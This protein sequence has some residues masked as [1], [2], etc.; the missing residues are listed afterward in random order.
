MKVISL[1]FL[2]LFYFSPIFAQH[3]IR[4]VVFPELITTDF[5][6]F[7]TL[8]DL[9]G[10]PRIFC[11]EINA[12]DKFVKMAGRV[13]WK[14]GGS[15]DFIEIAWFITR[16]FVARTLCNDDIGKVDVRVYDHRFNT[17]LIQENL[18]YGKPTGEYRL[19]VQLYDST[20]QILLA[21]DSRNLLFLNPAQTITIV[22]PRTNQSYDAGNLLVEWTPIPGVSEYYIKANERSDQNQ[23]LEDALQS[24]TPLVNKSVGGSNSINLRDVLDRELRPGSEIVVQVSANIPGPMGETK[25]FSEIVNFFILNPETQYY[26]QLLI[27]FYNALNR[28]GDNEILQLLREGQIDPAKL[29]IRNEDGS[30]M[31]FEELVNFLEMN[32]NNILRITKE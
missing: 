28:L 31:T 22:N 6:A 1:L 2:T 11:A 32:T 30:I 3:T 8:N 7:L 19:T 9:Q 17:D 15:P 5:A 4:L 27:R 29:Q 25:I 12:P 14:R 21:S 16:P 18:R 20:G 26:Q 24:G 10:A 23:S 13:E